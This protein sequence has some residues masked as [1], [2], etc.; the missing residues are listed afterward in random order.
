MQNFT[1]RLSLLVIAGGFFVLSLGNTLV[2]AQSTA[3]AGGNGIRISPVRTDLTIKPGETSSLTLTVENITATSAEFEAIINDFVAGNNEQGQPALI[4]DNNK[5][6]PSHSLKRYI[7][8]IPNV[9]I[10]AGESKQVKVSISI[11]N[12]AAAGGYY[13]AVRFSPAGSEKNNNNVTLS[14]SVGSL[15]LVKVPGDL[16]ENLILDSFDVR[17]SEGAIGGS[18]LFVSSNSLYAVARFKNSGNVHEQ[19]F[20]KILLKRGDKILQTIEINNT[21]PKGNVLPDSTRRFA[22]KLDKVGLWGK[23]TVQGN[24]GYGSGGQ[25]ISGSTSFFVFPL[26]YILIGVAIVALIAA[27]IFW[28]PRAVKRYNQNVIRR[29]NRHK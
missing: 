12:S 16:K 2:S 5:F 7:S 18:S 15:I 26:V 27:A 13:G 17:T 3:G 23:Y 11:P 9:T 4:L 29:A 19:P 10:N 20:G 1:K 14:A 24:F 22:V 25:L 21:D 8:D 6:A 28:L